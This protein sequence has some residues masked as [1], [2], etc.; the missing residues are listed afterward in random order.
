INRILIPRLLYVGQFMTLAETEWDS[1]FRPVLTWVKHA[2][3]LPISFPNSALK[4]EGIL[5]IN[6]PW[7][8]ITAHQVHLLTLKLND[9]SLSS[10]TINI[11][12][13]Q[14]QL[15]ARMS[16]PIYQMKTEDIATFNNSVR[17]WNWSLYTLIKAKQMDI[18]FKTDQWTTKEWM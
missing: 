2:L 15:Q 4:H 7:H 16:N 3:G 5:G 10:K 13:R 6:T 11:R 1:L 18:T 9:G 17:W 12:L 8:I 14:A